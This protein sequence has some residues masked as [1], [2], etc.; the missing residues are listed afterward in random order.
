M[1]M[2]RYIYK[3]PRK[4]P[5]RH[6]GSRGFLLRRAGYAAAITRAFSCAAIRARRMLTRSS[7]AALY[8]WLPA[9]ALL[10]FGV[11]SH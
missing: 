2:N 10:D 11:F 1:H 8:H 6:T 9:V 3:Y 7:T 4:S 5:G